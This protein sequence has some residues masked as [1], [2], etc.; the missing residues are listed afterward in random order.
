MIL[1]AVTAG[2][3]A[4]SDMCL[5]TR[6]L[7]FFEK[8]CITINPECEYNQK[9]S[10][11]D[12]YVASDVEIE[13]QHPEENTRYWAALNNGDGR[14]VSVLSFNEFL[15]IV[16]LTTEKIQQMKMPTALKQSAG[17]ELVFLQEMIQIP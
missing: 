11:N 5:P 1:S 12:Y 17:A 2:I 7:T 16:D 9:V 8:D 4:S 3:F 6:A 13:N 14:R 10:E 15:S